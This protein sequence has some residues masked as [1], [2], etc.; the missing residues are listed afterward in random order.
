MCICM[1]V[2]MCLLNVCVYIC[3]SVFMYEYRCVRKCIH[4]N[5]C[6]FARACFFA[7]IHVSVRGCM[8]IFSCVS[9]CTWH[10]PALNGVIHFQLDAQDRLVLAQQ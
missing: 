1:S 5:A 9:V 7:S 4:V 2:C 6:A 8:F 10:I 3:I